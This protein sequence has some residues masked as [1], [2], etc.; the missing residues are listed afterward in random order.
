MKIDAEANRKYDKI[1]KKI[2]RL[3][4]KLVKNG[5]GEHAI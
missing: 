1:L 5:D 4:K 3:F 2:I